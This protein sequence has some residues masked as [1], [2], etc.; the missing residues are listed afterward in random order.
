MYDQQDCKFSAGKVEKG[1]L[2]ILYPSRA[3]IS[4]LI[5]LFP[6]RQRPVFLI[7]RLTGKLKHRNG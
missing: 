4:W 6:E 3:V 2:S 5:L 7:L 1:Q